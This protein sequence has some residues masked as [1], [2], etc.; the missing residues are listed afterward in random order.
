[1]SAKQILEKNIE[2]IGSDEFDIDYDITTK[3]QSQLSHIRYIVW[4]KFHK[5]YRS[6]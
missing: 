5:K 2:S 4:K 6:Q 1:M 3:E